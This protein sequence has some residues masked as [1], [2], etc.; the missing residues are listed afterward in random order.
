MPTQAIKITDLRLSLITPCL[1]MIIDRKALGF[2]L[3]IDRGRIKAF[4]AA[5]SAEEES[6]L[7]YI[8]LD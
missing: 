6:N 3:R 5:A 1:T 8:N 7:I 4:G 2:N